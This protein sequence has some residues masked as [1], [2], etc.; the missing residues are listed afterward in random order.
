M[1]FAAEWITSPLSLLGA[2]QVLFDSLAWFPSRESDPLRENLPL[3]LCFVETGDWR[4]AFEGS[5]THGGGGT[6]AVL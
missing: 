3:V 5:S 1:T 6:G 2:L 4:L